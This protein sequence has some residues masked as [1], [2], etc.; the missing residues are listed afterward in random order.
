MQNQSDDIISKLNVSRETISR[1]EAH[2]A[3]V[4]K[5][6]SRVNLVSRSS[7]GD[8]WMRHVLDS[9]QLAAFIP[10]GDARIMDVGSGAGF[11]GVVLGIMRDVKLELVE[12]D[13]RKAAFLE[14][15]VKEFGLN[16]TIHNARVEAMAPTGA[17]IITARALAPMP[18]LLKFLD[19]HLKPGVRCLLHKGERV[20]EDLAK[21]GN[22]R[23]LSFNLH[24]SLTNPNSFVVE[25][26]VSN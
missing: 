17:D 10:P 4:E 6:Q 14:A 5:W 18:R 12:S 23:N 11:P 19:A 3:L 20:H 7:V 16:A 13:G 15:A 2:M 1:L 21:V 8:M 26:E 9:A 25:V 22:P 24:P